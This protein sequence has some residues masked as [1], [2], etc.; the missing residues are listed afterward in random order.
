MLKYTKCLF[1]LSVILCLFNTN[2]SAQVKKGQLI[3]GI[4]AVIGDEIVLESDIEDQ[5]NYAKQQGANVG[6]KCDF[7]ESILNNKLLIF[8]AKKDTLIE[9]RSA[10]IK[11]MAGTKYTQIL[12][13][14][15]DE[16]AMLTA[17]KFRTSYEMKTAI[18]KID[19]DNYYGQA[20]YGRITEKADVTPNE[21]TDFYNQFKF[22]LP[23]V[24]DEVSLSKISI[25]P[26]ISAAH[27]KEI[28][29]KLNKIKQDIKG[30]ES[31][32]N[33]ARIYSEDEGSA[34]LGGLYKGIN[35]GQ[36]VKPFEA[37][38]L[39]L[40]EGEMSDPIESEYGYHLIQLVKRNGKKYDAR[41][42]LI[43]NTPNADEIAAGRKELDSIRT[44]IVNN[45]M[46]FK[47]AAY[48]FSDD[49]S[50]KF[51]AGIMTNNQDGSDKLEK[52]G[53][54]P[55]VSYQIAGLKKNDV[56]EPFQQEDQ[57][58]RKMMS[59]IQVNDII[60]AHQL[61]LST[62]YE[63]IKEMAL[64]KKKNEIVEKWVNTK[65]PS[66]FISLDTKYKD[67]KFHSNWLKNSI[68]TTK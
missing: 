10:A 4:A 14:F 23:N 6:D 64:N 67:C 46:S 68:V 47:D 16:K 44:L 42:I 40:Q 29:D 59:L 49:K 58:K 62:D 36:M 20:K 65:I 5:A 41:H 17:Y 31:F 8:E 18:E 3:D 57:Q 11:E 33:Q 28:I 66:I 22:Q 56:T 26:K 12:S 34:A 25:Y 15:P 1:L 21:V 37:A 39:N 19:A 27:K 55:T 35:M 45:K 38:A 30:G 60:D 48:K 54:D 51:S 52:L 63:R 24:K 53:L 50:N 13:Q 9:N 32:E 2:L 61:D 7:M 43:K